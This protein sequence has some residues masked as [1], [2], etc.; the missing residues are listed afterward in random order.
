MFLPLPI[1]ALKKEKLV[2]QDVLLKALQLVDDKASN[3]TAQTP[4]HHLRIQILTVD[5]TPIFHFG[6]SNPNKLHPKSVENYE[7]FNV[8]M[9]AMC[10]AE[11]ADQYEQPPKE[12]KASVSVEHR[13]AM[14]ESRVDGF[15]ANRLV[16]G[17]DGDA[18]ERNGSVK[19]HGYEE[20]LTRL[21]ERVSRLELERSL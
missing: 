14:L 4:T 17:G 20:R 8:Y 16:D 11:L 9:R 21:E 6:L 7:A 2:G 15:E 18:A 1:A 13:L 19:G 10:E 5:G 12:L 3:P